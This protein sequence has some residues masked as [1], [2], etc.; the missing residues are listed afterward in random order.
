VIRSSAVMIYSFPDLS[1]LGVADTTSNQELL[2]F[3]AK[4]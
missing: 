3:G 1:P 4:V 2:V